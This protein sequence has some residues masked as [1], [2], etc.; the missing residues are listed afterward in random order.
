[1]MNAD[2]LSLACKTWA[3]QIKDKLSAFIIGNHDE[4]SIK[5]EL[6]D[7]GE[8]IV[9]LIGGAYLG[10]GGLL[11][12]KFNDDLIYD[13]FL[14]HEGKGY[15]KYNPLHPGANADAEL[16]FDLY[17]FGHIHDGVHFNDIAKKQY[18]RVGTIRAGGYDRPIHTRYG[19]KIN[20]LGYN[21]P[22]TPIILLNPYTK[23]YLIFRKLERGLLML[24]ALNGEIKNEQIK[25]LD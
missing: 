8:E 6:Y 1:M 9:D 2:S 17:V 21:E 13:I 14:D 23:E 16:K 20:P 5:S 10:Y 25:I 15:S 3:L 18:R 19:W 4:R 7:F 12:I 22:E 11:H 24:H